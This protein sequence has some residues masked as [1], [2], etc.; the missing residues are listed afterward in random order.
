MNTGENGET[1]E[2]MRPNTIKGYLGK[3][4]QLLSWAGPEYNNDF[5]SAYDSIKCR[6]QRC[7][8]HLIRDLNDGLL[9]NPFDEDYKNLVQK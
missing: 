8:I 4:S 5:Y 1:K 7:L 6:H 9:K 3:V 2:K